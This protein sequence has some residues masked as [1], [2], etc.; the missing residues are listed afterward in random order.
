MAW[1]F[2][3]WFRNINADLFGW[4]LTLNHNS[5]DPVIAS[6]NYLTALTTS[7]RSTSCL[8][9]GTISKLTK[10]LNFETFSFCHTMI[11]SVTTPGLTQNEHHTQESTDGFELVRNFRKI[12]GSGTDQTF[13]IFWSGRKF[14]IFYPVPEFSK[15]FWPVRNFDKI[16]WSCSDPKSFIFLSWPG[17]VPDLIRAL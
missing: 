12:F 11:N 17:L 7:L 4:S 9:Y 3:N 10:K 14:L 2:A 13:P 8:F 6:T 5:D 16:F 15:K 1:I